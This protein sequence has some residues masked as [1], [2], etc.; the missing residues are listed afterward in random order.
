MNPSQILPASF[1]Q[2]IAMFTTRVMFFVPSCELCFYL[3]MCV[4]GAPS[5]FSKQYSNTASSHVSTWSLNRYELY[6]AIRYF[7]VAAEMAFFT[8]ILMLRGRDDQSK[9]VLAVES[10]D[11]NPLGCSGPKSRQNKH[12]RP[13][14]PFIPAPIPIF[15]QPFPLFCLIM[16]DSLTLS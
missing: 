16:L 2:Q 3:H 14:Q 11:Q 13:L 15:V 8:N 7:A 5:S 4:G 1:K 9:S 12:P 6:W 10:T